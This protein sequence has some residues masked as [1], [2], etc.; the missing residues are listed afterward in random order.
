MKVYSFIL[1]LAT[2]VFAKDWMWSPYDILSKTNPP[3][4]E[5]ASESTSN[6]DAI[7]IICPRSDL[8]DNLHWKIGDTFGEGWKLVGK[9]YVG[10]ASR[11][12]INAGYSTNYALK[13][14]RPPRY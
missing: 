8:W 7:M 2:T 13:F 6:G 11:K 3:C 4:W 9:E 14:F 10:P 1:V 5:Y 12:N